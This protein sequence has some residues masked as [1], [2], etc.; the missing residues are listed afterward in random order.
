MNGC[1]CCFLGLSILIGIVIL[2]LCIAF[3]PFYYTK[4]TF[5]ENQILPEIENSL[6]SK[7]IYSL[8]ESIVCDRDEEK[9]I[10]GKWDG[11]KEGCFCENIIFDYKCT[12]ELINQGCKIIPSYNSINYQIINS[13]Y[14]CVKQSTL[15]YRD[16]ILKHSN[17]IVDKYKSC[18]KN[19]NRCC[20]IIDTLN[21][22]LCVKD[23][24]H[25]PIN[26]EMISKQLSFNDYEKDLFIFE[27]DSNEYNDN[28][29]DNENSQILS[30]FKLSQKLPC[31]NP[32][33]KYWDYH[34]PL[35]EDNQK[36]TTEIKNK[37]YDDRFELLSNFTVNKYV[38]YYD[39]FIIGKLLY[40]NEKELNEIKKDEVYLYGR[41]FLG[42]TKKNLEKYNYDNLI[43]KQNISNRSNKIMVYILAV[44]VAIIILLI[45][46][47]ILINI[48]VTQLGISCFSI[49]CEKLN[50]FEFNG[51][52]LIIF[53]IID[54]IIVIFIGF[55]ISCIIYHQYSK[56]NSILYFKGSDEYIY[57]LLKDLMNP[58]SKNKSYPIAIIVLFCISFFFAIIGLCGLCCEE[59]P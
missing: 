3:F 21:R 20:G 42:F 44:A 9:L 47:F 41:N 10:L 15:S 11:I 4:Y 55:I 19:F 5:D 24:D 39:N 6:N 35:E 59:I 27:K 22:K 40:I 18:P 14:I 8:R 33:E 32:K 23:E 37:K 17:Q 38:L 2:A 43:S 34:Y 30:L 53:I 31:I 51:N 52:L 7:F 12:G 16:L 25:C 50:D 49:Q 13:N 56:I 26:K 36:C 45:I 29:D 58:Y 28:N 1:S 48:G 46:I 54:L 57:E